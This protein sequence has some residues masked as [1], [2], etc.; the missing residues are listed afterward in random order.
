[1]RQREK[2][3]LYEFTIRVGDKVYACEREVSGIVK[4][5]QRVRVKGLGSKSD[6]VVYE[7]NGQP[8]ST[9]ETMAKVIA[10]QIIRGER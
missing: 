3:V 6:A 9:M 5:R 2:V 10:G 7:E 8:P 1:M 4:L